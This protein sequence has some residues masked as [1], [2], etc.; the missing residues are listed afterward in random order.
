MRGATCGRNVPPF[1]F[2]I[3]T[4]TPLAGR[5][6]R[7][8]AI[9]ARDTSF[10]L[11]RPSRGATM[12]NISTIRCQ[13]QFL[14]TRPSRG[15][16]TNPV[17]SRRTCMISTHT[18]LA[19]RDSVR[20]RDP[21]FAMISTHTPLAGRDLFAQT[22]YFLRLHFYSHAPRGA[23]LVKA[24]RRGAIPNFYSHA[25]RGARQNVHGLIC[26]LVLFLLTRPSRGATDC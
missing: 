1:L 7:E 9:K 11:T 4:H 17:A 21:I 8:Q 16:T 5:D 25:P 18:P 22:I 24:D 23:R 19:G 3:S 14:L 26:R 12:V 15:A 10:L 2:G 20:A 13:S 6:A